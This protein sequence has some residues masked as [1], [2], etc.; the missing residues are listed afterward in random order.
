MYSRWKS[1]FGTYDAETRGRSG[2]TV[3]STSR[4]PVRR[5]AVAQDVRR[6][7]I[8]HSATP[9]KTALATRGRSAVLDAVPAGIFET[10]AEGQ[11]RYVN[12]RGEAYAGKS[13]Q[14]PAGPRL[15]GA[16]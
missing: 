15:V 1:H 5:L 9:S 8:T 10:D 7:L 12:R 16:G 6:P 13:P 14:A 11:C 2:N 4:V 3:R